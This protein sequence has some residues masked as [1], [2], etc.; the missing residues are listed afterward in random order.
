MVVS[1]NRI[2]LA[3]GHFV[4]F[5]SRGTKLAISKTAMAMS[6]NVVLVVP[7]CLPDNSL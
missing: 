3:Y 1:I 4:A 5:N 7:V 6:Y 2:G